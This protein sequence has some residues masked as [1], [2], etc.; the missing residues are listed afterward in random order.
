MVWNCSDFPTTSNC[1]CVDSG[2]DARRREDQTVEK[3]TFIG[4]L[5]RHVRIKVP[6]SLCLLHVKFELYG[7]YLEDSGN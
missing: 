2:R 5:Y 6:S 7:Y 1:F 4:T 3:W